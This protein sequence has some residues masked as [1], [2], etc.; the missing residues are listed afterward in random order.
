MATSEMNYTN[1]ERGPEHIKIFQPVTG[2]QIVDAG[3]DGLPLL[4]LGGRTIKIKKGTSNYPTLFTTKDDNTETS[5][6]ISYMNLEN[7]DDKAAFKIT[8]VI[9]DTNSVA[10]VIFNYKNSA[11]IYGS[12]YGFNIYPNGT[13]R[14]GYTQAGRTGIG[15]T[16]TT[17]GESIP[18]FMN[19]FSHYGYLRYL[20]IGYYQKQLKQIQA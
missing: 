5:I 2:Q 18:I 8:N 10:Y 20:L 6:Q 15:W 19:C 4:E 7:A 9:T 1:N 11:Y 14:I 13:L 16:N 17:Y 3:S 12:I